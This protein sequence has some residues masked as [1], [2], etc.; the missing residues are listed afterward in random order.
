M[1][2]EF[3]SLMRSSSPTKGI[4]RVITVTRIL[5]SWSTLLCLILCNIACGTMVGVQ[6]GKSLHRHKLGASSIEI[7]LIN[8]SIGSASF[9][10]RFRTSARPSFQVIRIVNNAAPS[11]IGTQP[12][13]AILK[14]LRLQNQI[15]YQ[16][17]RG[18]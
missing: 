1:L 7:L 13:E 6:S 9:S 15:Q 3:S 4:S 18:K 5:R 10:R 12:P 8:R 16:E 11:R 14:T 2:T 17:W